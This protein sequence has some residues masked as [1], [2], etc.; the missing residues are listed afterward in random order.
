MS[1]KR[2]SSVSRRPVSRALAR[3]HSSLSEDVSKRSA[4]RLRRGRSR[5][6][7][8]RASDQ[9]TDGMLNATATGRTRATSR[10]AL[11]R[12]PEKG[13]ILIAGGPQ[14]GYQ[15][16]STRQ[17]LVDPGVLN[18]RLTTTCGCPPRLRSPD[19]WDVVLLVRGMS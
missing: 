16:T 15:R 6:A 3:L 12:P 1:D 4:S 17:N 2:S 14:R 11:N 18:G 7:A 10:A 8:V 13:A 9:R 5:F 19:K